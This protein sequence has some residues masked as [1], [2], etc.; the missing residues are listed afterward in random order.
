MRDYRPAFR[1]AAPAATLPRAAE[2]RRLPSD[3]LRRLQSD[4]DELIRDVSI[5][6]SSQRQHE[7]HV[8]RAERIAGDLRAVFRGAERPVHPPLLHSGGRALW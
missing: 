1:A 4:L 8:D 2:R 7:D 5:G 6:A 3:E